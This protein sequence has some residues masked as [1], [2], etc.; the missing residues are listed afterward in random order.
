MAL[1]EL[2]LRALYAVRAADRFDMYAVQKKTMRKRAGDANEQ[3][4]WHG[5][6]AS[7][8]PLILSNGFLRDF[9][10]RGVYGRGV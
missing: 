5:T 4:M 10:E 8:I 7:R 2:R 9:N 6:E 1:D 3:W